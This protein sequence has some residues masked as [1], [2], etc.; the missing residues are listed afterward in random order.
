MSEDWVPKLKSYPHFDAPIPAHKIH[1]IVKDSKRV[2]ENTFFPFL[3]YWDVKQ[4]FGREPAKKRKIRYAARRDSYI[5]A[6]YRWLLSQ[7]YEQE[8]VSS[9]L[10][11]TVIAYR[12]VPIGEGQ[13]GNK[14]NIYFARDAFE[15]I[16]TRK[17]CI[18][19]ALDISSYFEV[20][21]HAKLER[22]WCQLLDVEELP[23]DHKSVFRHI[24]QYAEVSF[25]EVCRILGFKGE[26]IIDGEKKFGFKREISNKLFF[27]DKQYRQLCTVEDFR[28]KII[29]AKIVEKNPNSYGLP[30]GSPISDILANMNLLAFDRDLKAF[31]DQHEIFYRRYSDDLLFILPTDET[32]LAEL[33]E[34]VRES[35]KN[36]GEM[37]KIKD[38]KTIIRRFS[39]SGSF[40][41][42]VALGGDVPK[43]SVFDYLGFRFDGRIVTI[44]DGTMHNYFRK[45]TYGIRQEARWLSSRYKDKT[46]DEVL[47]LANFS[48]IYKK[49]GTIEDY[50]KIDFSLP[51]NKKKLTYIAYAQKS[52]YVFKGFE[53]RILSQIASHKAR[54]K[55]RLTKEVTEAV[56]KRQSKP[57]I[58]KAA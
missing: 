45:M 8:L 28:A 53:N 23:P 9:G 54:M 12:K 2:K 46:V 20:I 6:Y 10:S 18:A 17:N 58:A 24:T 25:D 42:C 33:T 37:L 40:L 32:L 43:P 21:D 35:L 41:Q 7:K 27:T 49:Y 19:V 31:C 51:R 16:R 29:P 26:I 56:L 13:Q 11:D 4:K 47:A 5:Y 34:I 36:A 14:S 38:S 44:K 15:E 22:V 39:D 30:Q 1:G 3:Y 50:R 55:D 57:P 48:I 52:L